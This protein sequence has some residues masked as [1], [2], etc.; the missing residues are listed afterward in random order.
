MRELLD[1]G[2]SYDVCTVGVVTG[3]DTAQTF[4]DRDMETPEQL[5]TILRTQVDVVPG[6]G[7]SVLNAEDDIVSG[8]AGLSAG[9][10]VVLHAMRG[11]R[12]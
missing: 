12:W 3:V 1:E 5:H 4:A 9:E 11:T 7:V 8:M 2:T 10:V 6:W